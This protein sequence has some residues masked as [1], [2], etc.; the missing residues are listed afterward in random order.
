MIPH[1]PLCINPYTN[2]VFHQ[3]HHLPFSSRPWLGFS[4]VRI[5]N[6]WTGWKMPCGGGCADCPLLQGFAAVCALHP[7]WG[8]KQPVKA[9]VPLPWFPPFHAAP[10][11]HTLPVGIAR[12]L[13]LHFHVL[14]YRSAM[15]AIAHW[16]QLSF[17]PVWIL[18][19]IFQVPEW[20]IVIHR[21]MCFW[22]SKKKRLTWL[23]TWF[24]SRL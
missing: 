1:F 2:T 9:W 19:V 5:P 23:L 22:S 24:L 4:G 7:S 6:F 13:Y 21:Q 16:F 15:P 17:L 18:F 11:L 3:R 12:P 14:E 10:Q 20:V 8:F